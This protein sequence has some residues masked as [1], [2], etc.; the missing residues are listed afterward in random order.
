MTLEEREAA[1]AEIREIGRWLAKESNR[2][3]NE[4]VVKYGDDFKIDGN[5]EAYKEVHK[6]FSRRMKAVKEK[7][8]L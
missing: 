5:Q 4:L 3:F 1:N 7:Y 6:E 8:N 2:I